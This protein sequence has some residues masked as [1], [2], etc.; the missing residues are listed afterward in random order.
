MVRVA[1]ESRLKRALTPYLQIIVE[2]IIRKYGGR[3]VKFE[4]D[5]CFARFRKAE[6]AADAAVGIQ[7][8]V[9]AANRTTPEDIDIE[10][11]IGIDHGDYLLIEGKDF[12]GNPVNRASKLGE[13]LGGAGDILLTEDVMRCIKNRERFEGETVEFSISGISLR[14]FRV[15]P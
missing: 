2:P 8:A 4:A 12:F 14:A 1:L 11:S 15:L 9:A 13:D 3:V 5:N 6:N 7:I 10:V